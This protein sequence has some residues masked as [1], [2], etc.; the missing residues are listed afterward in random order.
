MP[1]K[2]Y[3]TK[4]P[5]VFVWVMIPYSIGLNLIIF[6]TCIF[7]SVPNFLRSLGCSVLYFSLV[8]FVFG[9][10]AVLAQRRLPGTAFM[11][12]R[13][14]ILLPVFYLLNG[15]AMSGGYFLYNQLP[16]VA[17]PT[18]QRMFIWAIAYGCTMSTVITLLNEGFANWEA[19]KNSLVETEKLKNLYQRSKV[20]GL[21]GQINP[22][23]LFNCFNTL[24]GL[25]QEDPSKAES[26]L[27]EMT[28]VHRYLLRSEDERFVSLET[29]LNFAAS[30][31]FLA[32]ERFGEAIDSKIDFGHLPGGK[33]LPPFSLQMILEHIIYDNALSKSDPL[34]IRI[35]MVAG[36]ALEIRNSIRKKAVVQAYPIGDG[37]ENLMLKYYMLNKP[38]L[39]FTEEDGFRVFVLPLFD[40][41]ESAA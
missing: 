39:S 38:G 37:I 17:C 41:N 14:A 20:L 13:L 11:V 28:K 19:W 22:H 35:R 2:R 6:G 4:E 3:S 31:L 1:L 34:Q 29:E 7:Q 5:M 23:F 8:Y 12:K 9:L 21:Q 24:S 32:R 16:L 15:L 40:Q 18:R 30:Y 36:E 33:F 26:F 25:I 27:D 10:V